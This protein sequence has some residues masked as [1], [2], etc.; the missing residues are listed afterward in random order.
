MDTSSEITRLAGI[1]L[2]ASNAAIERVRRRRAEPAARKGI[3]EEV[4]RM[5]DAAAELSALVGA[6]ENAQLESSNA[7][8]WNFVPWLQDKSET[9]SDGVKIL[10]RY[11][12]MDPATA[13]FSHGTTMT[14]ETLINQGMMLGLETA[15]HGARSL[16]TLV[17]DDRIGI[18]RKE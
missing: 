16:F 5:E 17:F 9:I 3:D 12:R 2:D 13:S 1:V 8:G 4:K 10:S 7:Q 15:R 6:E 11:A 18:K 14:A